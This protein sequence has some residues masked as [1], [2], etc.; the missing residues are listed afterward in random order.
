MFIRPGSS[1]LKI[2]LIYLL[3]DLSINV[4]MMGLVRPSRTNLVM[5]MAEKAEAEIPKALSNIC[6]VKVSMLL[7]AAVKVERAVV[8]W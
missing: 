5:R 3:S 8:G 7:L 6:T 1:T 4:L 2:N